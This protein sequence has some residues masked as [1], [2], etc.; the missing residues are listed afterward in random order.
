LGIGWG[1]R[2]KIPEGQQKEGKHETLGGRRFGGT[3]QNVPGTQEVKDSQN[4][5]GGALDEIPSIGERELVKPMSSRK[6]A[7][8]VRDGVAFSQSKL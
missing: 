3:L 2:T 6:T 7:H 1:E 5:K 8:Q 4:S